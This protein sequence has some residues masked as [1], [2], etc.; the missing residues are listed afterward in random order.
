MTSTS[1]HS[2]MKHDQASSKAK[3]RHAD[4]LPDTGETVSTTGMMGAFATML[5]GLALL[6]KSKKDKKNED[7]TSDPS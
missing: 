2:T 6:K 1:M 3:Q 4:M 5:T 7:H